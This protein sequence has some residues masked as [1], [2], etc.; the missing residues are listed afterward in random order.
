MNREIHCND[1]D[2]TG[3]SQL[4]TD[5]VNIGMACSHRDAELLNPCVMALPE[6]GASQTAVAACP[7][8]Q[9]E[10]YGYVSE[11]CLQSSKE[12]GVSID[13]MI[14][15]S[16]MKELKKQ[17]MK[18]VINPSRDKYR[19]CQLASEAGRWCQRRNLWHWRWRSS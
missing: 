11:Q 3:L 5:A 14:Y 12:E 1:W 17:E 4:D 16:P 6:T 8:I 2:L 15:R 13:R 7:K 18:R 19:R 9:P 10:A